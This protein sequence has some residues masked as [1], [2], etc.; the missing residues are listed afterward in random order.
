MFL[1]GAPLSR[2]YLDH[3]EIMRGGTLR[4]VMQAAPNKGWAVA[5]QDRP[6]STTPY[7]G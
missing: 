3:D 7:G 1:D 6:F 2:S 4:F 5:R